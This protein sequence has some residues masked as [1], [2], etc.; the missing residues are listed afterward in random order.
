MLS[1]EDHIAVGD[2]PLWLKRIEHAG[3]LRLG[4]RL[5]GSSSFPP[6]APAFEPFPTVPSS[7]PHRLVPSRPTMME[8]LLGRAEKV[9]GAITNARAFNS[10]LDTI[11]TEAEAEWTQRRAEYLKS[12][13]VRRSE[14][15]AAKR[16]WDASRAQD[17]ERLRELVRAYEHG[18]PTQVVDYLLAC[19][20]SLPLPLWCP[21]EWEVFYRQDEG[22]LLLSVRLPNFRDLPVLK[23]R[24]TKAGLKM[25]PA[26]KSET[27]EVRRKLSFLWPLRLMWESAQV[28]SARRITAVAC[29]A[30]VVFDDPATGR[31]R[32]DT[33]MTVVADA[34]RL[35]AIELHKV[36]PEACFR[37]LKGIAAANV[38]ELVPVQPVISFD[39]TD[40]R[41]VEGRPVLDA[42]GDENLATM[43]WQDF[44]HLVRELF[45]KEFGA[46]VRITQ[47]SRDKGVDAVAFDPDPVR[48]GKYVIQAKRYLHTVDVSAVR[49]LYGTMMNE[50][51]NR[52]ILVTT[53]NFGRDAYDFSQGKP[54]TLLNGTNLLHLLV[55]H[56]Y[57]CRIDLRADS[58]AGE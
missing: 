43:D 13:E 31:Q 28:D 40:S 57:H 24:E 44:E 36:E 27:T 12:C 42:L 50:G 14:W 18:G 25:V 47:A 21:R 58:H 39:K 55:K 16:Q 15:D 41:F 10:W 37:G 17:A 3:K 19:F 45:E 11:N 8:H 38:L 35:R 7:L 52:G 48:G 2:W 29:N 22:L 34:D 46:D 23:P 49:D 1:S 9:F 26:T 33:I 30:F 32:Q 53:S 56:G 51:A 20:D 4:A 54:I 5:E 6:D